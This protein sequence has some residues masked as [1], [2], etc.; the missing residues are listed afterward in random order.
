MVGANFPPP[1]II[2]SREDSSPHAIDIMYYK[3]PSK[4]PSQVSISR[5]PQGIKV[6]VGRGKVLD[7][8]KKA[9]T[10]HRRPD[11]EIDP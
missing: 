11:V 6:K 4:L 9:G 5:M 2:T 7:W 3:L 8:A 10:T 1:A